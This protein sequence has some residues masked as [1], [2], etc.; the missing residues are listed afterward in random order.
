MKKEILYKTSRRQPGISIEKS[1][2]AK[3]CKNEGCVRSHY[4]K[5]LC[6]L[7]YQRVR[8]GILSNGDLKRRANGSACERNDQNLKQCITCKSWLPESY[9]S[10]HKKTTDL[11]QVRCK[12]CSN[13]SRYVTQYRITPAQVIQLLQSQGYMCAICSTDIKGKYAIDHDHTCCKGIQSCGRCIR[14]LLCHMC[15]LGLGSFKD[16]PQSLRKAISYLEKERG[17]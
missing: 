15:N 2:D 9:F 12:G 13:I 6:T 14:G 8:S 17:K 3:H 1:N 16:S 10:S 5:G 7:H 11:L 4:A